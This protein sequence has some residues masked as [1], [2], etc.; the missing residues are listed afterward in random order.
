MRVHDL[1]LILLLTGCGREA[2]V[3]EHLETHEHLQDIE[4]RPTGGGAF[5]YTA[6]RSDGADCQGDAQA[7]G[8]YIGCVQDASITSRTNCVAAAP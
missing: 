3:R 4:L 2:A 8:I 1:A 7:D 6:K 5:I